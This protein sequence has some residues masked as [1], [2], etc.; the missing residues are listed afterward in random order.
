MALGGSLFRRGQVEFLIGHSFSPLRI[1]PLIFRNSNV[2]I[3][4]SR[5]PI[6]LDA[7]LFEE[8]F[9]VHFGCWPKALVK[10]FEKHVVA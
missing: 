4:A 9:E 2:G 5:T 6:A 1:N 3:L 8:F 7:V 10:N